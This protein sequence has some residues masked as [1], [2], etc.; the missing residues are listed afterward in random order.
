MKDDIRQYDCNKGSG[1]V[2]PRLCFPK[3]IEKHHESKGQEEK[4]DPGQKRCIQK[5]GHGGNKNMTPFQTPPRIR[6]FPLSTFSQ[7]GFDDKNDGKCSENQ[8]CPE[9]DEAWC[10]V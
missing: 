9:K 8:A 5:K 2:N 3:G 6:Q 7:Y 10:W 1:D 4:T